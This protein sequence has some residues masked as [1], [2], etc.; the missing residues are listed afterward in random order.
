MH[1]PTPLTC[2]QRRSGS[3]PCKTFL[4]GTAA[5]RAHAMRLPDQEA[6][7]FHTNKT[8]IARLQTTHFYRAIRPKCAHVHEAL[9]C[10]LYTLTTGTS[11]SSSSDPLVLYSV[12]P[13]VMPFTYLAL[14]RSSLV[15]RTSLGTVALISCFPQHPPRFQMIFILRLT[16]PGPYGSSPSLLSQAYHSTILCGQDSKC[17]NIAILRPISK[18]LKYARRK[19]NQLQET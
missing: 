1:N 14:S 6:T 2:P 7:A 4:E 10:W 17:P 18:R 13:H 15:T 9:L 5:I 12:R 19:V 11:F 8:H 16:S 3:S